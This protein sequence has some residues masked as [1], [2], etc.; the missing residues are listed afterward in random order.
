MDTLARDFGIVVAAA[1]ARRPGGLERVPRDPRPERHRRAAETAAT[2]APTTAPGPQTTATVP[3]PAGWTGPGT[4]PPGGQ[5][6]QEYVQQTVRHLRRLDVE[7]L[8][9]GDGRIREYPRL[10]QPTTARQRQ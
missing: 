3:A 5:M 10:E 1:L 4:A 7:Q 9:H 8:A 6:V 2:T